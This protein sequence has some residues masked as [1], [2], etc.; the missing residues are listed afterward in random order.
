[1]TD[2]QELAAA[3]FVVEAVVEDHDVK[4]GLLA[5]LNAILDPAGDPRQ[6]HLLAVDR[7]ARAGQR[8]APSASSAC[9]CSTR[10]RR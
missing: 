10:S 8:A 3:T 7:A 1:M 4:A 9:T 5:E 6:H 2:P